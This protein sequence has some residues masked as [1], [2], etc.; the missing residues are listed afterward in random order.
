LRVEVEKTCEND[1]DDFYLFLQKQ[2]LSYCY[3]PIG[4]RP[5]VMKERACVMMLPSCSFQQ[6][7]VF[8][9]FG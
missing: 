1:D 8:S 6:H 3:I 9:P 7:E 5:P 4:Y 2:K